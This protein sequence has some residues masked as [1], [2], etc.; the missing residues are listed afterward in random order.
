MKARCTRTTH[1]YYADY[2]GRGI[3]VCE[4]WLDFAAFYEDMGQRPGSGF[5]LEREDVNGNYEPGNCRW[6]TWRDQN[7]NRRD[8]RFVI[9]DGERVHLAE[10]A[11]RRGINYNTVRQRLHRGWTMERALS[12]PVDLV[13]SARR[14]GNDTSPSR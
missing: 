2:G 4:R 5:S 9:L 7:K 6:A 13:R 3:T 11:R 14:I 1:R 10:A 8:N 12:E